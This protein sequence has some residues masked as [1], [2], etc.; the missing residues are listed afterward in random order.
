MIL[1]LSEI[2]G[3]YLAGSGGGFFGGLLGYRYSSKQDL[4]EESDMQAIEITVHL[5][6]GVATRTMTARDA[7]MAD[8]MIARARRRLSAGSSTYFTRRSL[9][10]AS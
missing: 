3:G 6:N 1:P 5:S 8:R 2:P 7:A 10:P 9:A 4:P